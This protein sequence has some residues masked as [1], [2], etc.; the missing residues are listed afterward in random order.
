MND[1]LKEV[2]DELITEYQ[3]KFST[4]TMYGMGIKELNKEQLMACIYWLGEE[5][6]NIRYSIDK[7]REMMKLFR[8]Q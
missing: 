6:N 7:E 4:T 5:M 2:F 1:G 8:S 3:N